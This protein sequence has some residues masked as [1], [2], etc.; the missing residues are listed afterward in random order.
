MSGREGD[1]RGVGQKSGGGSASLPPSV[2]FADFF[3]DAVNFD[4]FGNPIDVVDRA[5]DGR[6]Q[7]RTEENSRKV[8]ELVSSGLSR[9]EV[10]AAMGIAPSTLYALFFSEIGCQRGRPGRRAHQPD[11]LSRRM[12]AEMRRVGAPQR[13]IAASLNLS[14]PTLRRAYAAEL[15][16]DGQG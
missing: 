8:I 6:R 11:R 16:I 10:A 12:V 7:I 14:I 13:A 2:P 15:Q 5:G 1:G 3:S 9:V 4:L